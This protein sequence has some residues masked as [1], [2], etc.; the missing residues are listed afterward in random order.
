[1]CQG[2]E[3]CPIVQA[4]KERSFKSFKHNPLDAKYQIAH[5]QVKKQCQKIRTSPPNTPSIPR[6]LHQL[7]TKQTP[8][9]SGK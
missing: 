3:N 7:P 6:R 4:S 1:M 9:P 5:D 2:D 8:T